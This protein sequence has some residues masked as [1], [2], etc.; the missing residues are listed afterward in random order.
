MI[1]TIG[2]LQLLLVKFSSD[3]NMRAISDEIKAARRSGV[4]RLVDL[5]FISKD[6]NG[7]VQEKQYTDLAEAEKA[8]YGLI[9]RGLLGMRAAYKTEGQV[10]QVAAAM[11][12]SPG[13]FGMTSQQLQQIADQLPNG[14]TAILALFE[15]AWAVKLKEALLNAGGE[16]IAQGL[17]SPEALALGGTTLEEAVAA[18]QQI[19]T[20]AQ[21]AVAAQM[22]DA[23]QKLAQSQ[24]EAE[25]KIAESQRILEEAEAVAA[26]RMEEAKMV[27]AAAIAAS[28]RT[29]ADELQQA[30]QSK[31]EIEA[32]LEQSR[33]EIEALREQN[34]RDA[35]EAEARLE[36]SRKQIEALQEQSKLDAAA[37]LALGTKLASG[38]VQAGRKIAQETIQEGIQTAE[39]IKAAAAV[40][41]L[42][43]LVEA[44]LIK[45][46]AAR[47][48]IS[49]LVSASLIQQAAAE[50]SYARLMASGDK[51]ANS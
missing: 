11:S 25:A 9:L 15:H 38:E 4:I 10:D 5:I 27:A 19:E 31:K 43:I 44:Q 48:A 3:R 46:E 21:Q 18:A 7:V 49:M 20:D 37:T 6:M 23:D 13:D 1:M 32:Q 51:D 45:R 14:G 12:L 26:K 50:E 34:R 28:V 40:E 42:R 24:A 8:E 47:Q 29:A 2:P 17:L 39:E 33:L 41:A 36:Q 16:L 22:A 30:E 35:A